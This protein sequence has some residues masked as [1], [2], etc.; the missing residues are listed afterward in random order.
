MK[1]DT[2]I[3]ILPRRFVPDSQLVSIGSNQYTTTFIPVEP[4][5][6]WQDQGGVSLVSLSFSYS[7][8]TVTLTTASAPDENIFMDYPLYFC[9]KV[10]IRTYDDPVAETGGTFLWEPRLAS[11]VSIK[12]S[13]QN[14]LS[15]IMTISSTNINLINEDYGLNQYFT[16]YDNYKNKSVY[17]YSL[18]ETT[19]RLLAKGYITSVNLGRNIGINVKNSNKLLE[20][21][22]TLNN[23]KAY[24]TYNTTDYPNMLSALDGTNIKVGYGATSA[25]INPLDDIIYDTGAFSFPYLNLNASSKLIKMPYLGLNSGTGYYEWGM[26]ICDDPFSPTSKS[27][28]ATLSNPTLIT[29]SD[30]THNVTRY[31]ISAS[32][33]K[34]FQ[35]GFA[36]Q[37]VRVS[38]ATSTA[39]VISVD[40]ENNK[41]DIF[42]DSTADPIVTITK[43][44]YWVFF[45]NG[46]FLSCL[47]YTFFDGSPTSEYRLVTTDSSQKLAIMT[48]TTAPD[49]TIDAFYY[50]FTCKTTDHSDFLQSYIESAGISVNTTSFASVQSS[51]NTGV[52]TVV[53]RNDN[54]LKLCEKVAT[55]MGAIL[56]YDP[57]NDEYIYKIINSSLSGVDYTI[58]KKDILE[59]ELLPQISYS[60][61]RDNISL[62]H[63]YLNIDP[64]SRYLPDMNNSSDST[65]SR[66]FNSD[67]LSITLYHAL[68]DSSDAITNIEEA[69]FTPRIT[70]RF[71]LDTAEF[72]DI[73]IG[74]IIKITDVGDRLPGSIS[75][76]ETVVIELVKTSENTVVV[77][78]D[79]SK[80]P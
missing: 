26:G 49:N 2:L 5:A 80:I 13:V 73:I 10:A 42:L 72:P 8:G 19:Y 15:G 67:N 4:E 56:S 63:E 20:Y 58:S 59:P 25:I 21:Q 51:V 62:L 17:I 71:T 37:D 7:N 65:F 35:P 54:V 3:K 74:D 38:T 14:M 31:D 45:N 34:H 50:M 11:N 66:G 47:N 39:W 43:Y 76:I 61:V 32:D 69:Y 40:Y 55:S 27:D 60:D 75:E 53:D 57:P 78:Y 22:A 24:Q 41:I 30:L 29:R 64:N 36:T 48:S 68:E 23:S 44:S 79:F 28:T 9:S 70:Y 6:V 52:M 18:I 77:A 12:E 33:V 1:R 46:Q 16:V